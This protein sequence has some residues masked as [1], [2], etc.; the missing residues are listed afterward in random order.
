[1]AWALGAMLALARSDL[2]EVTLPLF[3]HKK[4]EEEGHG[5]G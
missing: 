1:M 3:S 5:G 2:G 4:N